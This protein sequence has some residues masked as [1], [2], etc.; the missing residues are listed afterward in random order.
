MN[1]RR[2][3]GEDFGSR[4]GLYT[5]RHICSETTPVR[6]RNP[7][8]AGVQQSQ[9]HWLTWNKSNGKAHLPTFRVAGR[10]EGLPCLGT[11]THVLPAVEDIQAHHHNLG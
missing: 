10:A 3:V 8:A 11:S 1:H 5:L 4:L 6:P 2:S 9:R 7:P